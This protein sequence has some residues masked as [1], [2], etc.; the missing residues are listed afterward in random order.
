MIGVLTLTELFEGFLFMILRRS[1]PRFGV[2]VGGLAEFRRSNGSQ[3]AWFGYNT[4][5][6]TGSKANQ[7]SISVTGANGYCDVTFQPPFPSLPAAS[8]NQIWGR[9]ETNAVVFGN[10]TNGVGGNTRGNAIF[11]VLTQ[12][13]TPVKT[14][15]GNGV[16]SRRPFAYTVIE[17]R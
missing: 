2:G 9:I 11:A 14:G 1:A 13:W 7:D 10:G 12:S 17:P 16:S 5:C 15:D 6:A 4:I 8:A 3:G